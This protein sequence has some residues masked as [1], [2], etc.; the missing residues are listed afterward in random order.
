M[1]FLPCLG[2]TFQGDILSQIADSPI[3][4]S[5]VAHF[6]TA[7]SCAAFS[8]ADEEGVPICPQVLM[9]SGL[10]AYASLPPLFE[11]RED[12]RRGAA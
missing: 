2:L 3:Q 1:A 10:I 6:P 9:L 4:V 11:A 5:D 8:A 12:D 7:V